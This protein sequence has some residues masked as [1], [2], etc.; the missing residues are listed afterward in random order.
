MDDVDRL[1]PRRGSYLEDKKMIG[2][3]VILISVIA[4]TLSIFLVYFYDKKLTRE[5]TQHEERMK[6]K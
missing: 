2:T 6:N 5:I 3:I 1:Y 4:L